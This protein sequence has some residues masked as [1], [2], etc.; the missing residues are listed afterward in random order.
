MKV[1][2]CTETAHGCIRHLRFPTPAGPVDAPVKLRKATP[3]DARA[4]NGLAVG[5][6]SL[7]YPERDGHGR[8]VFVLPGGA[9]I[10]V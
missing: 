8:L 9:E 10:A 5:F 6:D 1:T 2:L 4:R 3:Y 7:P